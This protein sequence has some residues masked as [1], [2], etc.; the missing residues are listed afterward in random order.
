MY[1][2]CAPRWSGVKHQVRV[3][4]CALGV[5]TSAV[6]VLVE[7]CGCVLGNLGTEGG[8]LQTP[9]W[10]QCV[11][12]CEIMCTWFVLP[13]WVGAGVMTLEVV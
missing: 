11:D 8:T 7:V 5:Q 1:R 9:A 6:S 12:C 13:R 2:E 4:T 10:E 3:A